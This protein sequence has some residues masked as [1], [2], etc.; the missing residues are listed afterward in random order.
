[1]SFFRGLDYLTRVLQR[2]FEIR[3]VDFFAYN[4]GYEGSR[5]LTI[6]GNQ[7]TTSRS[8]KCALNEATTLRD[9]F[10]ERN[11]FS[12]L[13]NCYYIRAKFHK[14]HQIFLIFLFSTS[15]NLFSDLISVLEILK[16]YD[17]II[18]QTIIPIS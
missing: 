2:G 13:K 17:F 9:P 12:K 6:R 8:R 4:R 5:G 11:I 14:F 18:H 16:P 7:F 15:N 3:L 10:L 1:M